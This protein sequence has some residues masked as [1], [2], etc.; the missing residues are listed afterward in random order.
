M[1]TLGD[2]LRGVLGVPAPRTASA[3][4]LSPAGP[5]G[6]AAELL[7][8]VWIEQGAAPY[9]VVERKYPPG[10][11]HGHASVADSLPPVS[12]MWPQLPL[13]AAGL[14]GARQLLFL[15]L[16]TTGLAG[17]AGTYAFLVGLGWFDG[18]VF[19][20]RQLLLTDHAAERALLEDLAALA[21]EG[22]AIV[23]FNGRSFDVPLIE[24]RY[25]FH[26]LDGPF[27]ALPHLD[28]LPPARRLW[29]TDADES[30]AAGGCRLVDLEAALCGYTREGDVPG[31]E[32]PSRYFHF[33]RTGDARPLASVL[34][35][36]RLDILS[37][38]LLTGRA[39]ALLEAGP[40]GTATAREALGLG[41]FY[42][43]AGMTADALQCFARAGGLAPPGGIPEGEVATRAIA[44]RAYAV[45]CRR[46]RRFADAAMAWARLLELRGAPPR[47]A[48]EAAEALAVHHEHRARDL[49]GAHRFALR[50]LALTV[51]RARKE[52]VEHR[53]ARLDRKRGSQ[54]GPP[55]ASPPPLF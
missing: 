24:T 40:A 47:L 38:A 55:A 33:V 27:G 15:D 31:F 2:R 17:G 50:T 42:L 19:R 6:N 46:V 8:G 4:G 44:L 20:T 3:A 29:R 10:H 36:N 45:T 49:D 16:E 22:T 37:L 43:R 14:R 18:G 9:L 26:R 53:L 30:G 48:R 54:P 12:G 13:L 25:A 5:A 52:A 32:I 41:E 21:E 51:S 11:C 28:M 34:E 23:S 7:D 39:A 35:H 1:S